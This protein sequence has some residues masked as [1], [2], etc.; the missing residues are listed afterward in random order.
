VAAYR[1]RPEPAGSD[2]LRGALD[3][4]LCQTEVLAAGL[5]PP[6]GGWRAQRP[7]L[8][9]TQRLLAD[10]L[11]SMPHQPMVLHRGGWPDGS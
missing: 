6:E 5:T 3:V 10:P 9:Q 8:A 7:Y 11:G 4:V 1:E 2:T